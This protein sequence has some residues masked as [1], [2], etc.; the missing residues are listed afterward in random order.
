MSDFLWNFLPSIR[1]ITSEAFSGQDWKL[2]KKTC[3][4]RTKISDCFRSHCKCRLFT[5]NLLSDTVFEIFKILDQHFQ[6][7][8]CAP[9]QTGPNSKEALG[10]S[11]QHQSIPLMRDYLYDR[12]CS[13]MKK[14]TARQMT[15][16]PTNNWWL[17]NNLLILVILNPFQYSATSNLRCIILSAGNRRFK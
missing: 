3:H 1:V 8:L 4:W 17:R 9:F 13:L 14:P 7:K 15:K 10:T 6:V 11:G 2:F 16:L 12:D 5:E